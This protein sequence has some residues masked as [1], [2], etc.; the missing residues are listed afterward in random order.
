MS[1]TRLGWL[2]V[3]TLA[4]T[5]GTLLGGCSNKAE[6]ERRIAE[7]RKAADDKLA[8]AQKTAQEQI[9][10]LQK[11]IE[12]VKAEA[13]DASAQAKAMAEE[14]IS[15]AQTSADDAAKAAQAAL[16]KAREAYKEDGRNQLSALNKDFAEVATQAK[17]TPSKDKAAYDKAIKDIV[18][19]QK[20][21]TADIAEFDKATLETFKTVKAKLA[22]D[23][24]LMKA[25]IKVAAGKLPKH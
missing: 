14:A 11:Q 20:E 25:S 6:E 3:G 13:A 17:K 4:L 5:M 18:T 24:A 23:L 12:T 16:K 19:K 1:R 9:A 22:K 2:G 8:Q 10:Q 21:I 15:K 7:V